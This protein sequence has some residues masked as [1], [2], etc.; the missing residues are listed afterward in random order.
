LSELASPAAFA[1]DEGYAATVP[2]AQRL[3]NIVLFVTVMLS[4]I[5]F[6]E[7]SPHDGLMLI[8]LATCVAA[9]I[10]FDRK[11]IPLM[12]LLIVWLIGG[13]FS[14]I[15]VLDQKQALQYVGTSGYLVLAAIMFACL[16]CD[17][18]LVRLTILQRAYIIA[19]LIATAAGYVGFFHLL[20]GSDIF[21]FNDRVSATFKD[22]NVYGPFLIFP[23]LLLLIGLMTRGM[24]LLDLA[25]MTF[26]FGG[27]VLS[28]S[29]G[30][31]VH[32]A[33]SAAVAVLLLFVAAPEQHMRR[34]ILLFS[35]AV[36]LAMAL[37]VIALL[38]IPAV[39]DLFLERA[40]VIQ[41]YD[42]GPGGRFWEQKLALSVILDH[43]NG[44][45]PFEF[46]RKYGTQ[47]HDVYMQGFLVYGWVGGVAYFTLVMVTLAIGLRSA[48]IAAPW[49]AY[50][51]A[52][53]A[54]FAGEAFEG[55][56]VDTD[57]WRHFFL[58]L[59][60][61]WGL[62]AASINLRRSELQDALSGDAGALLPASHAR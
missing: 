57:H 7:P 50:L 54:A 28:F 25:I 24:R 34:R 23:L 15:P 55:F 5:A 30:A 59:G 26:L 40:K 48:L 16:F 1:E 6:I 21:L 41:P 53:Y 62:T 10:P 12:L 3:L 35:V 51:I 42:V 2:L 47:Q 17:G 39:H 60:L 52:A 36:L 58:L 44:L 32:F 29:R 9:R 61:V 56:I 49:Q 8:L 14:V 13:F 45:G 22:P 18:S 37:F 11:L 33:V 31:W 38:L 20:P 27:L 4:S 19:A 43:P 46:F